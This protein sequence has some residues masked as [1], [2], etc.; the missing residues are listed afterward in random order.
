MEQQ[1]LQSK[2]FALK[3]NIEGQEEKMAFFAKENSINSKELEEALL[4]LRHKKDSSKSIPSF[5]DEIEN[6]NK[7]LK[8]E[9]SE[10]QVHYI[11]SINELE[12]TRSLLR[13][14]K[15]INFEQKQEIDTL[16][17]MKV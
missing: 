1:E 11:E 7:D 4:F 13:V 9:L 16:K 3:E 5:L 14:Q 17:N 6:G 2:Y 10:L 8:L 12:K 15:D